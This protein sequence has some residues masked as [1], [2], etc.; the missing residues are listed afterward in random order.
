VS[1]M[2]R[3][4]LR[5]QVPG[6]VHSQSAADGIGGSGASDEEDHRQH[7]TGCA[8]AGDARFLVAASS[9]DAT[10]DYRS[11]KRARLANEDASP[12]A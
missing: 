6:P 4:F 9:G 11:R 12:A 7:K 3:H 5:A 8:Q 10:R 1:P 2:Y